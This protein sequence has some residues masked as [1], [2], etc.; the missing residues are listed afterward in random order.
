MS[1][2]FHNGHRSD[3]GA[4]K[5]LRV[6]HPW[7]GKAKGFEG[8]GI[9]GVKAGIVVVVV[10]VVGIGGSDCGGR[11]GGESGGRHGGVCAG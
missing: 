10:V 2:H 8:D 3:G 6:L 5:V 11:I 1:H 4:G 9:A 7:T